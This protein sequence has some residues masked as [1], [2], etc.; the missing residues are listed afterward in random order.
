M[1]VLLACAGI[2]LARAGAVLQGE[3][4]VS[5]P[6]STPQSTPASRRPRAHSLASRAH[7]RAFSPWRAKVTIGLVTAGA[8]LSLKTGFGCLIGLATALCCGGF[9]LLYKSISAGEL[10]SHLLRGVS[11]PLLSRY[12]PPDEPGPPS[13]EEGNQEER[14]ASQPREARQFAGARTAAAS[15][16]YAAHAADV[17]AEPRAERADLSSDLARA[18]N[19]ASA[20]TEMASI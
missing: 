15:H 1:G 3:R 2:E 11:A 6:Q 19:T 9:E 13:D 18:G 17:E 10:R 7:L 16:V 5:T 4:D 14:A 12:Q 8:T 20:A